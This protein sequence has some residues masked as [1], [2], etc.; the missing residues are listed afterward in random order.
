MRNTLYCRDKQFSDLKIK[1]CSTKFSCLG[2]R[3][4]LTIFF[5][6]VRI[7]LK[8][9][10]AYIPEDSIKMKKDNHIKTC[11]QKSFLGFFFLES[12]E[13]YKINVHQNHSK[14]NFLF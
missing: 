3:D 1:F 4:F 11:R 2:H 9:G 8:L 6:F 5:Y 12:S 10:C 13:T 14:N 7:S